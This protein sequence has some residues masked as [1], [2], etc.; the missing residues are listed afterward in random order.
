[1]MANKDCGEANLTTVKL[2]SCGAL[3]TFLAQIL[4]VETNM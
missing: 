4:H 2:V 1:M 3:A